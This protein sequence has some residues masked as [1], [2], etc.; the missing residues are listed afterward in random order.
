LVG[1][2]YLNIKFVDNYNLMQY[3]KEI[4]FKRKNIIKME[5]GLHSKLAERIGSGKVYVF[6]KSYC[7]YCVKAKQ[8]LKAN[9]IDFGVVE[10]DQTDLDSDDDFLKALHSNSG[11]KTFPKVYIGTKCIGGFSDLS[12]LHSEGQLSKLLDAEG[13]KYK[14]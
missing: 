9:E 3:L 11:S 1:R 10:V 6:S 7:P 13:V 4:V 2:N 8:L 12:K 5:S 14:V